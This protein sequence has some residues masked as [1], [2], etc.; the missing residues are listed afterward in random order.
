MFDK[1]TENQ[2]DTIK[3][4]LMAWG[5]CGLFI[6]GSNAIAHLS[7]RLDGFDD[8]CAYGRRYANCLDAI[9]KVINE[10]EEAE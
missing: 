7:G 8:G 3:F 10:E 2:K 5:M 6:A 9:E 4:G 1:L